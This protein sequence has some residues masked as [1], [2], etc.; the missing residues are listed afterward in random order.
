MTLTDVT[1]IVAAFIVSVGGAGGIIIGLTKYL[2]DRIAERLQASYQLKIDKNFENYKDEI[3]KAKYARESYID[4]E[5][6]VFQEICE[7]INDLI[8]EIFTIFADGFIYIPRFESDEELHC[9]ANEQYRNAMEKY[10]IANITLAAKA[11][12]IP[13]SFFDKFNEIRQ[14][15]N[16]QLWDYNFF[17][18]WILK[19]NPNDEE[20]FKYRKDY[21]IRSKELN[22]KW[23]SLID[24]LRDYL[25]S[26]SERNDQLHS[27][28]DRSFIHK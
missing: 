2:T 20:Y 5:M 11:A 19:T 18:P 25:K 7:K 10:R 28:T 22:E 12:F 8:N 1:K 27:E 14:L 26:L 24:E 6:M 15:A 23:N 4:R 21:G 13:S 3:E 16:R 17:N 9:Y